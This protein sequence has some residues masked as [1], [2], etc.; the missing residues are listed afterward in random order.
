MPTIDL[1]QSLLAQPEL[2]QLAVT[3]L[4]KT[5]IYTLPLLVGGV[6]GASRSSAVPIVGP[7]LAIGPILLLASM[8]LTSVPLGLGIGALGIAAAV[9]IG[10]ALGRVAI[11]A[12]QPA[13][14][15]NKK[16]LTNLSAEWRHAHSALG[17]LTLRSVRTRLQTAGAALAAFSFLWRILIGHWSGPTLLWC[18]LGLLPLA[19]MTRSGR[20]L[21]WAALRKQ[22]RAASR[23]LPAHH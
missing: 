9:L 4:S 11:N 12:I 17:C 19:T 14:L 18:A 3:V 20:R 6:C 21:L 7:F 22:V 5:E 2:I 13:G 23:P 10:D 15:A 8:L 1:S 16:H